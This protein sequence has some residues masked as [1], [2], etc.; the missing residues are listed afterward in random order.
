MAASWHSPY[1]LGCT[2]LALALGLGTGWLDLHATEVTVT[3]LALLAS[4]FLLG[5][6]Q[7]AAAWRW[8]LLLAV[9][10]PIMELVG[11]VMHVQT[12]EPIRLDPRVALVALAFALVGCY[13]GVL[14]RRGVTT[15][16]GP[17]T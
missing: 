6:L 13:A 9:G 11:R 1:D 10:L 17:G 2:A 4:G 12:P 5:L 8:A 7:P 15:F 3:I 14:V 16:A